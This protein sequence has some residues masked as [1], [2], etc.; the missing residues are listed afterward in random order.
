MIQFKESDHTYV[1]RDTKYTSV[2]TLYGQYKKKQNWEEIAEAYAN[3]HGETAEYWLTK[4]E[5]NRNLSGVLGNKYHYLRETQDGG[6]RGK[7]EGD[8]KYAYN[9]K[10]LEGVHPE[11][12]VWSHYYKVAGQIDRPMFTGNKVDIL[13]Y[14]TCKTIET[15]PSQ[16]YNKGLRRKVTEKYKTPISYLPRFN[17]NDFALQMSIYGFILEM[18]GYEVGTLAI[19]HIIFDDMKKDRNYHRLID[20]L[21]A[22]QPER[23]VVDT[24][25]YELPYLRKEARA[26]LE[27]NRLH[28]KNI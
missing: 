12:I 24:Q 14:K 10:D 13:D 8:I 5:D 21:E 23:V 25:I 18:Y 6:Y 17:L 16:Y 19:E 26:L 1:F 3:K 2:T 7:V 4:W 20:A 15:E 27:H 9:L 28:G 22:G 11:L